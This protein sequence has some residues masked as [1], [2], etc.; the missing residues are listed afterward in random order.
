MLHVNSADL[1]ELKISFKEV[2]DLTSIE[3]DNNED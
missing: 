1:D 2:F 3:E